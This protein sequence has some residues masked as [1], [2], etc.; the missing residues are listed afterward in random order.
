MQSVSE[1][2]YTRQRARIAIGYASVYSR[3]VDAIAGL[4]DGPRAR[5]AFLL[6]CT[7]EPPWA[8]RIEDKAPLSP[9]AMLCGSGWFL[10]DRA[11][12]VSLGTGDV[13]LASVAQKVGYRSPYAL[14]SA[15]KRVRGVRPGQHR[16]AAQLM[17]PDR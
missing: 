3:L 9:V 17:S 8:L 6:R 5:R 10:P 15:F 12:P 14:S 7:L 11:E 1:P 13:A 2:W 4:L 16:Q